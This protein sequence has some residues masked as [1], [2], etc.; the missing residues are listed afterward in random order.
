MIR[1]LLL[2]AVGALI[3]TAARAD[4]CEA[5]LPRPG[6]TFSG[7]VR[8]VG[9]GDSLCVE[10]GGRSTGETWVEVRL[11]DFN[12]PELREPDGPA[13]RQA[14]IGLVMGRTIRCTARNRTFD[15]IAADC[16]LEGARLG[17]RLRA[18]GIR[19]GGN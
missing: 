12:A 2:A 9:D 7:P 13:A 6:E 17:D 19:E 3:A 4:P 16:T 11:A 15:R 14:L 1:T 10:V 8:Y 5:A 18:N